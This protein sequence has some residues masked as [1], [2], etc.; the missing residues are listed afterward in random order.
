MINAAQAK[1]FS[2][3]AMF[4]F[5]IM[6]VA[7]VTAQATE[8]KDSLNQV[9]AVVDEYAAVDKQARGW[10]ICHSGKCSRRRS[11]KRGMKGVS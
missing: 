3:S 1:R 2:F 11:G 10:R 5:L 6:I 4:L 7:A 9:D 8:Q